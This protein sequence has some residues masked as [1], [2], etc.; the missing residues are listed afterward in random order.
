MSLTNFI[1]FNNAHRPPRS[2]IFVAALTFVLLATGTA[3]AGKHKFGVIEQAFELAQVTLHVNE[4][5]TGTAEIR[6]CPTCNSVTYRITPQTRAYHDDKEVPIA[7]KLNLQGML[8][9][10]Y[11]LNNTKNITRMFWST[12][13]QDQ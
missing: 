11:Y 12:Q 1:R 7:P 5:G 2:A 9:Q 8:V 10:V 3:F 13:N 4:N 6:P